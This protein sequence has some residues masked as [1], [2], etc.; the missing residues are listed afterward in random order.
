MPATVRHPLFA[1]GYARMAKACETK[2]A[3]EHR[4]ELLSGAAGR[5]I[6]VGAG[7]GLNFGH[8]PPEVREV[9]AVEPEPYLRDIAVRAA[10]RS[11][12]PVLVVDGT[13]DA[14]PAET[15]SFDFGWCRWCCARYRI[16]NARWPSSFVSSGPVASC[17]STN[18]SARH[19]RVSLGSKSSSISAGHTWRAAV[20]PPARLTWQSSWQASRYRNGATS[21]GGRVCWRF[22]CSTTSSG[23][24]AGPERGRS[25]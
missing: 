13:A 12:V 23:A 17:G 14:L 24:P 4:D 19:Q 16:R 10:T 9:L 18:T 22:P 20:T 21:R 11:H 6:E 3:A 2:G 7:S 8:Y 25:R 15:E 5:G 1:R